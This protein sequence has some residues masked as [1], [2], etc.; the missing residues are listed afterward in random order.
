M[1]DNILIDG[2]YKTRQM[3]YGRWMRKQE[4]DVLAVCIY[5]LGAMYTER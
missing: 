3:V 1:I 2:T 4:V 5:E